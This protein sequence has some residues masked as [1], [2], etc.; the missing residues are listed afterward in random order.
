[1]GEDGP[2]N[3]PVD[4]LAR[5]SG[6]NT[7]RSDQ[8]DCERDDDYLHQVGVRFLGIAAEVSDVY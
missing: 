4:L 8:C 1:M 2:V 5:C 6:N 7:E 3:L